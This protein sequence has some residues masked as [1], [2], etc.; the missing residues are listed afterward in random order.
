M[1][2]LNIELSHGGKNF[3][4]NGYGIFTGCKENNYTKLLPAK[5]ETEIILP[6]EQTF[7]CLADGGKDIIAGRMIR[8]INGCT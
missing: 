5:A 4:G 2:M 3:P 1:F 6:F 8:I 7:E